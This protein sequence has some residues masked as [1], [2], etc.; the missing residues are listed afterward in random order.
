MLDK[1]LEKSCDLK[2]AE[3]LHGMP[4]FIVGLN[5]GYVEHRDI[6]SHITMDMIRYAQY[7]SE[8]GGGKVVLFNA[9]RIHD[10]D[11]YAPL[12]EAAKQMDVRVLGELL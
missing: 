11:H 5:D 3:I 10:P 8:N 7:L 9:I 2:S 4:Y 12:D 6:Q 1:S